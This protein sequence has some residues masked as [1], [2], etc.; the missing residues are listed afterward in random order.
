[1]D[2]K[3]NISDGIRLSKALAKAGVASRRACEKLIFDGSVRVNGKVELLPQAKVVIGRD[4]IQVGKKPI[5][6]PENKVYYLLN[7]PK[8][9]ICSNL[10]GDNKRLVIDLFAHL[11]Y[12]LFTVGRLDRDTTGLLILTNDGHFAQKVIHPSSNL[13]K[14]Y[15]VKTGREIT[16]EDLKTISEGVDIEGTFVKPVSVTKIRKATVKVCVREGKKREV[17]R[18]VEKADLKIITLK[19]IRIGGLTLG[20]LAEGSFRVLTEKEREVIFQ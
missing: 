19:R 5:L 6:A 9:F 12:R 14:S 2:Y 1:M 4:Q 8:N 18:L 10:H 20:D 3:K 13:T 17:R 11:P 7:K 16:H 15:L